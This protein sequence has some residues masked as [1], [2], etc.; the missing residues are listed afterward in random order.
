MSSSM[1]QSSN[2]YTKPCFSLSLQTQLSRVGGRQESAAGPLARAPTQG[3]AAR[4]L[5][6][7]DDAAAATASAVKFMLIE[8]EA[9]AMSASFQPAQFSFFP[10][11]K[12]TTPPPK[13]HA[14][15]SVPGR[16]K[17]E[18]KKFKKQESVEK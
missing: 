17:I 14:H 1:Q 3:T 10:P 13:A 8:S 4:L 11:I 16:A 7:S 6:E 2:L 18:E 15:G 12:S 5:R 9:A